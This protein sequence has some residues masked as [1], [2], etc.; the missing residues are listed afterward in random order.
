MTRTCSYELMT[1]THLQMTLNQ[2]IYSL[3]ATPRKNETDF[4]TVTVIEKAHILHWL[5]SVDYLVHTVNSL[6]ADTTARQT[7]L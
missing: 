6:K 1:G 2:L 3:N 4:I 7:P 5:L